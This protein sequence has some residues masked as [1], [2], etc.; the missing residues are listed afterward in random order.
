MA[1]IEP[2]RPGRAKSCC[3]TRREPAPEGWAMTAVLLGPT[4]SV[5]P[6]SE[7]ASLRA[8]TSAAIPAGSLVMSG[9]TRSVA[10]SSAHTRSSTRSVPAL[11]SQGARVRTLSQGTSGTA[12]AGQLLRTSSSRFTST[13]L[14]TKAKRRSAQDVPGRE[15]RVVI[16]GTVSCCSKNHVPSVRRAASPSSHGVAPACRRA[17]RSHA[18]A[19]SR[20]LQ[21]VI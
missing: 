15:P 7:K 4:D 3:R 9:Q 16:T 19:R 5:K 13:R 18:W 8:P 12:L 2:S 11:G 6:C 17:D 20:I 21:P 1:L 10:R 14:T